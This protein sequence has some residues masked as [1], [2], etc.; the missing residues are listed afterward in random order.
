[1]GLVLQPRN[2]VRGHAAEDG[3]RALR[4]GLDDDE[5]AEAFQEVLDEPARV[6]AGLDDP[7]HGAEDGGGVR[8]GNGLHNVI[9]QRRVGVAKECNGKLVVQAVRPGAR[10][11]LVQDREGVTD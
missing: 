1:V 4:H 2:L 8:G 6:M 9:K 3:L 7:V 11:Q 10:H 5:V